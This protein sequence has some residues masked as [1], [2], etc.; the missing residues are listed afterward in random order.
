MAGADR[1][2]QVIVAAFNAGRQ[3]E[4]LQLCRDALRQRPRDPALNHLLAAASFALRDHVSALAA[5]EISL[6]EN[7]ANSATRLLAGR[8]A[9]ALGLLD[10]AESHLSQLPATVPEARAELARTLEQ[11]GK[12]SEARAAWHEVR[13]IEPMSREAAARLGR[14]LWED[15]DVMGARP[16]LEFAVTGPAPASAWFDLGLCLQD[17]GELRLAAEAFGQALTL[18][19]EDGQAAYNLAVLLQKLDDMANAIEAYRTAYRLSPSSLGMI[20]N[21]LTSAQKGMLFT[22]KAALKAFLAG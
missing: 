10:Q 18:K 3:A 15:Q 9:R 2:M 11:A 17:C 20:A 22:D 12:R 19:P 4:A 6:S 14:L 8:A 7:P 13:R 1:Q 21:A 5:A 16:H